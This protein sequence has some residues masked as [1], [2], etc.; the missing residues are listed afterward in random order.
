[1]AVLLKLRKKL[2]KSADI[3]K[4]IIEFITSWMYKKVQ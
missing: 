1:M 2:G 3:K 4:D